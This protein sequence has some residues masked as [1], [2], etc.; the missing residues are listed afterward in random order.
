MKH[1]ILGG[2]LAVLAGCA[3]N[4]GSAT[5]RGCNLGDA[6]P[7]N[8]SGSVLVPPPTPVVGAEDD[9]EGE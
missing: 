1:I 3:S 6:R 8:P 2:M 5:M 9:E 4:N 7:A